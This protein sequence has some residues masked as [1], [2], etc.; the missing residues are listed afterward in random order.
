M[1]DIIARRAAFTA[2]L[3]WGFIREFG[4]SLAW[5]AFCAFLAGAAV[6]VIGGWL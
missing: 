6:R 5:I 2:G 4:P 3:T 1:L